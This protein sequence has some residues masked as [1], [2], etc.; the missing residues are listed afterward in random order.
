ML[1]GA[2]AMACWPC[3]PSLRGPWSSFD[4]L[5]TPL[6]PPS[7]GS[8]VKGEWEEAWSPMPGS[9]T[10]WN[11]LVTCPQQ[12]F[13]FASGAAYAAPA[14]PR[15]TPST[16]VADNIWIGPLTPRSPCEMRLVSDWLAALA[17]VK[18]SIVHNRQT[19]GLLH[20]S[21]NW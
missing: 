1:A 9:P 19:N 21:V 4:T 6:R 15:P 14:A 5:P 2:T 17:F 12:L 20:Y 13:N 7:P 10:A 18:S 16:R 8:G 3:P 11:S